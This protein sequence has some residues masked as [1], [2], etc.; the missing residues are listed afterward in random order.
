MHVIPDSILGNG[1]GVGGV[2]LE[3]ILVSREGIIRN[4][5][6][7]GVLKDNTGDIMSGNSICDNAVV[8]AVIL[9][10]NTSIIIVPDLVVVNCRIAG[11]T[12]FNRARIPLAVTPYGIPGDGGIPACPDTE[13]IGST[14]AD[15]V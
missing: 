11:S 5:V 7:G 9:D 2:Q 8:M 6:Y 14:V 3:S 13:C 4:P 1:V 15:V 12:Y 10:H